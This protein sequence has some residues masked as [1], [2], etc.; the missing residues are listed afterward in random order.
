M[1]ELLEAGRRNG[2]VRYDE[3]DA[4][5][6]KDYESGPELDT[7]LAALERAGVKVV[8]QP[9]NDAE[10]AMIR[11]DAPAEGIYTDDPVKVYL[12]EVGRVSVLSPEAEIELAKAIQ[13]GAHDWERA[14]KDLVEANLRQVVRIASRYPDCGVH[15]LELIQEG[16]AGLLKAADTFDS[17]RGYR[18]S[19]YGGW[20]AR[21]F[22]IRASL[23]GRRWQKALPHVKSPYRRH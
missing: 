17:T 19:T 10:P 3:L 2:Y 20:L 21:R 1:K 4:L 6:P 8:V 16:N 7:V 12:Q 18:F 15:L 22:V 11:D 13:L 14:K 23:R 9:N 5:L